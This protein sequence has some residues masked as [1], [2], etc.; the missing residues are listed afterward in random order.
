M[1]DPLDIAKEADIDA[2]H[3]R[4]AQIELEAVRAFVA[5]VERR[6]ESKMLITHKL[7]GAHYAAMKECLKDLESRTPLPKAADQPSNFCCGDS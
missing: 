2:A 7:E 3:D 1:S 5:E 4:V 6:A